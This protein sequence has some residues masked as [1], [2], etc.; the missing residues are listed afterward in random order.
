MAISTKARNTVIETLGSICW[1]CSSCNR[2][3][4]G[5]SCNHNISDVLHRKDCK[6]FIPECWVCFN[7]ECSDR[8][9]VYW[10]YKCDEYDTFKPNIRELNKYLEELRSKYS[11]FDEILNENKSRYTETNNRKRI[12]N[13]RT[14]RSK[15][16]EILGVPENAPSEII[17]RNFRTLCIKYHPD[18]NN[19]SKESE[20]KFR[21][22]LDAYEHCIANK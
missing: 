2:G 12:T 8:E 14:T 9:T 19:N 3:W 21:E 6:F 11:D 16:Y 4:D 20:I 18:R 10:R 7:K 13:K 15:Y 17:K 1:I 5:C 22:I